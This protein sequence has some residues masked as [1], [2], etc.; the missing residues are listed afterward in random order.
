MSDIIIRR[1]IAYIFHLLYIYVR[2]KFG[3]M[4]GAS[5]YI[6]WELSKYLIVST[7]I[8]LIISKSISQPYKLGFIFIL[9]LIPGLFIDSSMYVSHHTGVIIDAYIGTYRINNF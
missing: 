5:P 2:L 3:R 9:L 4:L 1:T 6:P 8:V 7:S